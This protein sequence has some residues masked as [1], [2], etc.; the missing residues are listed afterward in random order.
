MDQQ[1]ID[2]HE[3][4]T[5]GNWNR[6]GIYRSARDSRVWVPKCDP[7]FGLTLNFAH[8]AAWWSLLGVG[9]VPMGLL[10]LFVIYQL[11]K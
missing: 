4:E 6:F 7:R 9:I 10:L 1:A 11:A 5:P 3:W 2:R 8:R